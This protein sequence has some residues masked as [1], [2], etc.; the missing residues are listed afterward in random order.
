MKDTDNIK[1]F[2]DTVL[3]YWYE[4]KYIMNIH[5]HIPPPPGDTAILP[6]YIHYYG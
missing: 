4:Y 6:E 3:V 1:P 2:V 5:I